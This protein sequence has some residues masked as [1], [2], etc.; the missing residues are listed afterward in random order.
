VGWFCQKALEISKGS[1][2][3]K[4]KISGTGKQVRDVLHVD[5]MKALYLLAI[6]NIES[7]QGHAF[8]IGGGLDNSLSLIELF[9]CL[10]E[11]LGVNMNYERLAVR[12]SDQ[13]F[14]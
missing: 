14:L 10:E 9:V 3:E 1:A 6:E 5:D 7:I 2:T 12:S 8:N 4:F 13:R 11:I